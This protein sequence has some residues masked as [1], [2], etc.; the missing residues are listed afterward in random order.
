MNR[1]ALHVLAALATLTRL[2][3]AQS[4]EP[5]GALPFDLAFDV[6]QFLWSTTLAVSPDGR[7]VAY[8]VR[9]PPADSNVNERYQPNGT[10]SSSVGTKVVFSDRTGGTSTVVCP[11]GSCWRGAWSPDGAKLAFYSDSAGAPQLWVYDLASAR[12]RRISDQVIK[13]KLW[14]GDEPRWS[15]DGAT[16]Y[17]PLAPEGEYRSPHRPKDVPVRNVAG[18]TILRSGTETKNAPPDEKAVAPLAAHMLRENL[19]ALAAM[20]VATGR[21]RVVVPAD[22]ALRP[23]VLRL[24]TSG[25]WLSW[26]SAFKEHGETNQRTTFDLGVVPAGGGSPRV[27]A[28]DLPVLGDYHRFNYAWHPTDDRLVYFK[29]RRLWLLDLRE[30]SG[31]AR[32]VGESLGDLAPTVHW[33]TRDG[34]S[35]VVGIDPHDDRGY[36]DVRPRGFAVVPLD[37]SGVQRFALDDTAWLYR[38]ILK[39]DERTVW[40]P[41]GTSIS[42][43]L[44]ERSTGEKAVVRFDPRTGRSRILWKGLARLTELTAGGHHDFLVGLYEDLGSP[45]DVYA[46]TADF[47]DKTRVSHIDPRLDAVATGTAEVFATKVPLH[48]GSLGAVRSAVL[49][50]AGAKRG[51]RLP[52][53]VMM[54]PG[55]D[56]SREA[57][58]F[59]GGGTVT[60]PS[61]VF[62]SRGYAVLLANLTLGPNAQAGNPIQEMADVLLPQVYR[63]GEL[64]YIDVERLAI[65]GQ[66][67]GGYGTASLISRT[68][69]FRAAV[70]VS[71]IYDLPG[72]YGHMDDRGGSFWIG[73]NEGGQA[74]MGTHPWA[75]VRRYIDNSPYYQADKIFTPL[76]IVHGDED[77]AYH[78]GQKLFTALRRLD[79]PAQLASYAGQGHVIYEW[80]RA[81]AVDA[82]QRMVEFFRTHLGAPG[83]KRMTAQ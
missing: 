51:D 22:S 8:D 56:V 27:I 1:F 34:R 59:G 50:P 80:K 21:V 70:A 42:V 2:A 81:A 78:D 40:Q 83:T 61:L 72:T 54:Y 53:I 75:N 77:M 38:T 44:E 12:A 29:D 63:A 67:F 36:G 25:R 71:G 74:R 18:V 65:S 52:T 47:G 19:A 24:S 68:N 79:R 45:P 82:A 23:S 13:A 57:E 37:G 4:A 64:G 32:V 17:V 58:R 76:L 60:V 16:I 62:T 6:R 14:T 43:L 30:G 31:P 5:R 20:D 66:S 11:G 49:L 55:G 7:R 35:V 41:D 10:P 28:R 48:D 69:L 9:H 46:F 39:A 15:P 33:F 73:W 3:N 26:L